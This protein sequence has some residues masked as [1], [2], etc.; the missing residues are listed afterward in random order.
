ML[1]HPEKTIGLVSIL[2]AATPFEVELSQSLID[3]LRAERVAFD[4]EPP[5]IA[6]DV[7]YAGDEGGIMCRIERKEGRGALVVSITHLR[8]SRA[9]PFAADV[10]GYQKHRMKKL[11]K[12]HGEAWK[13]HLIAQS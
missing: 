13:A 10:L 7:S 1:D 8:V 2:R 9:L 6:S 4:A 11:K 5:Y 3:R 12:Q